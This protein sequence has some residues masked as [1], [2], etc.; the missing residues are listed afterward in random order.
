V[1]SRKLLAHEEPEALAVVLDQ[2]GAVEVGKVGGARGS[3]SGLQFQ[4][5]QR[6]VRQAVQEGGPTS[7]PSSSLEIPQL[8]GGPRAHRRPPYYQRREILSTSRLKIW[9]ALYRSRTGAS[10]K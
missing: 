2:V 10:S 9:R 7:H 8:I 3:R 5:L 4:E 6:V 1:K